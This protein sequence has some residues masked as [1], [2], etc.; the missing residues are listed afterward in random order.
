[1]GSR[2]PT[3][4]GCTEASLLLVPCFDNTKPFINIKLQ[5]PFLAQGRS[6]MKSFGAFLGLEDRQW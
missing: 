3:S 4:Q 6:R 5:L 2:I 1:M